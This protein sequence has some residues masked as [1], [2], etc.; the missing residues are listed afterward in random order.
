MRDER[1]EEFEAAEVAYDVAMRRL[2][3]QMRQIDALDNKITLV[4]GTASAV[5]AL[6]A[7]FAASTIHTDETASVVTGVLALLTVGLM[8]APSATMGF[9]AYWF[10]EW[11]V[12]PGWD[13]LIEFSR[14]NSNGLVK[15]WVAVNCIASLETNTAQIQR[16]LGR[17]G[18]AVLF[19]MLE[20]AAAVLGM[21]A[22]LVVNGVI[23]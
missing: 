3:E 10:Y 21:L 23:S 18:L 11:S 22:I 4:I 16:K 14:N 15:S 13:Q 8:F 2:D 19:L 6:F 9:R 12:R 5:A 17:A 1:V 7:G 20:G